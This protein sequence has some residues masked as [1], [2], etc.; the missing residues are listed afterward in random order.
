[1]TRA[2][3]LEDL[4]DLVEAPPRAHLAY[5]AEGAPEAISVTSRRDA[6]RWLVTLP[7]G[8]SVP[9]GAPVVLLI[10]DGEFYFE[11]RGIRVRGTLR[12]AGGGTRE[13][14][15]EKITTGTTARCERSGRDRAQ[16]RSGH[17]HG[18]RSSRPRNSAQGDDRSHRHGVGQLGT[19]DHAALFR[20]ARWTRLH[21]QLF[22]I[23]DRA[24]Y[25]DAPACMRA[26][27]PSRSKRH[28]APGWQAPGSSN[29]R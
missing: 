4:S 8:A 14:V 22:D 20:G 27:T 15:P 2:A 25:R 21:E 3:G 16:G 1:M 12:E 13:V 9:D 29:D 23:A 24:Q 10:D 7:P 6:E 11:L 17:G 5:V 28:I 19:A 18:R 26:A